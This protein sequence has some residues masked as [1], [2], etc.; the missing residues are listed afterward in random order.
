MTFSLLLN[1]LKEKNIECAREN[2]R[3]IYSAIV[4]ESRYEMSDSKR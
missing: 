2:G 3:G 1:E 4:K